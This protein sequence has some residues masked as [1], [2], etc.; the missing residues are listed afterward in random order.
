MSI[1]IFHQ[2][3]HNSTWNIDSFEKEN[4][5]DGLILSP[6]HQ[7][8][9]KIEE[10]K[11]KIKKDSIFDPQFYLPNSQKRKLKTYPFFPET[12]STGKFSTK[13]FSL[14]ALEAARQC[15]DFQVEQGFEKIIIPA[16]FFEQMVS[17]FT[18]K[19]DIY[20]VRPFLKACEEMKVEIPVFLTVPI[21]SHM[22]S[23]KQY[24][25]MLLNWITSFTEIKGIYLIVANE[26]ENKQIS[27]DSLIGNYFEFLIDLKNADLELILGYS[28]TESLLFCLID[29]ITLTMGSFENTRM[30]SIDKFIVSEDVRRGPKSRIYIPKLFNW[31]QYGQAKHIKDNNPDLWNEIYRPTDHGDSAMGATIEPH[32]GSPSL[33]KHH[34]ICMNEQI[35]ELGVLPVEERYKLLRTKIKEAMKYYEL[36]ESMPYDL[37]KHGNGDHL[38]P[39]LNSINIFFQNYLKN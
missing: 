30:F 32:F 2:C 26:G 39:W 34:F 38:Q 17:D 11:D 9:S 36:I 14:V 19:Q 21:T 6:V 24:R 23:D 20:T 22:V 16:R 35:K 33:Y 29:D 10:L 27:S 25:E 5:G 4:C 7:N 18:E 1:K 31:V 28:N 37:E 13:D 12:I 8:K 15:L 3:G